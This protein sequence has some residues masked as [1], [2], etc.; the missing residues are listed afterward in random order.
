M[1]TTELENFDGYTK[2]F[3]YT[4]DERHDFS[5][6]DQGTVDRSMDRVH[7][8]PE[9]NKHTSKLHNSLDFNMVLNYY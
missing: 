7:L 6:I 2:E 5:Y 4:L 1:S 3:F 9:I 8:L